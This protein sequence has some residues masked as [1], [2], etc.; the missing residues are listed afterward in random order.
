MGAVYSHDIQ[1]EQVSHG[2]QVFRNDT[3]RAIELLGD[4]TCNPSLNSAELELLKD[5]VSREH[6]A[7]HTR[8]EE[9]LLSNAH[10]NSFRDHMMGQPTKGD[11]DLTSTIGVDHLQQFH[12]AHYY[13]D[14]MVVVATG[15]VNHDEIVDQV[16]NHFGNLPKTTTARITG[17]DKNVYAPSILFMRDDEM[18]NSNVGV[19]YDAP[20]AHH[21]DYYGFLLLKHM[22]GRYRIDEHAEHLNDTHKQ[23]NSMHALLGALPDVTKADAHYFPYSDSGLFGNYF[24][25]N[26]IFTRQMN[27]CGVCLPTVYGHY[28][29]DV[30]VVRGR[31]DIYNQLMV[32][33]ANTSQVNTDIGNQMLLLGR[34]VPRSE[35]ATRIAHIDNYHMKHLCNEWFYDAEPSFTS[36][37]PIESVSHVMSYKYFKIN[38][39]STVINAHHTLFN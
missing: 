22:F 1:K 37:G 5:D 7:N 12:A 16:N 25:G 18:V 2:L 4:M 32:G 21:E 14:N 11:R 23:Y 3:G 31:N 24:Y 39:M 8:Y 36:W 6:E 17:T 27:Y 15:D 13:G 20:S 9:T 38:T 30:E 34:R 29:N 19:F 35:T 10:Y 33:S 28:L 26:E